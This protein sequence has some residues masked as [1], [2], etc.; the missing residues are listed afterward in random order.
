MVVQSLFKNRPIALKLSPLFSIASIVI[1]ESRV[2]CFCLFIRMS[3]PPGGNSHVYKK[4]LT[5]NL[6][7]LNSMIEGRWIC[8]IKF[9][10]RVEFKFAI[11]PWRKI[12]KILKEIAKHNIIKLTMSIERR[13]QYARSNCIYCT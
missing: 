4:I 1:R 5:G 2:K 12:I 13:N 10:R 11:E 6:E 7:R 3:F 8:K 9:H